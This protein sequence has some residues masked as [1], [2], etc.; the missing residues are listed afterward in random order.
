MKMRLI[1]FLFRPIFIFLALWGLMAST[2]IAEKANDAETI[3]ADFVNSYKEKAPRDQ[4]QIFGVQISGENGGDWWVRIAPGG[5]V[6]LHRGKASRPTYFFTMDLATLRKI[7]GG[8]LNALTA[9]G[10]ARE[11]DTAPADIDVMEGFSMTPEVIAEILPLTFHFFTIG[12][13]E[14]IPFGEKYSRFVHGGNMSVF[15]YE[16]GLRTAWAEIKKGMVINKDTRDQVNPFPSLMIGIRGR[17]KA[18][19]GA[20]VYSLEE[21]NAVFI[22]AGMP[23]QFWNESDEPAQCIIIMFGKGA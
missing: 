11:S 15:Y 17:A 8:E 20:K 16:P 3:L 10:K 21:G 13:P 12:S 6:T 19:L 4:N 1:V 2:A 5:D 14:F 23:H 22:P 7:R 18:R 9:M